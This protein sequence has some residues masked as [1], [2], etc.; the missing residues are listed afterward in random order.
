MVPEPAGVRAAGAP[1]EEYLAEKDDYFQEEEE[2]PFEHHME[3]RLVQALGHHVQDS[4][5]QALIKALKAF[6]QPLVLKRKRD[7]R[8]V[9]LLGTRGGWQAPSGV[10]VA[11][12][13]RSVQ[14]CV[15]MQEAVDLL[16]AA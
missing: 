11:V 15:L 10:I 7:N 3:E 8:L 9:V 1:A 6:T 14:S 12:V 5:N 13:V 16:P 4:V 2:V